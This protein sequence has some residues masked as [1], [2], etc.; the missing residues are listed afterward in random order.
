MYATTSKEAAEVV[1]PERL[2]EIQQAV[3]LP[4]VA[5]GGINKSNLR[6]VMKTGANAA[7]VISAVMG[8]EDVEGATRQLVK[9][10]EEERLG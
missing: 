8:A 5:I 7:A 4:I 1:G 2:K 6:A 9:I 3:D 10:I